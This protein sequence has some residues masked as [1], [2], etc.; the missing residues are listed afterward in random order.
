M[1]N[2]DVLYHVPRGYRMSRPENCPEKLYECMLRCWEVSPD[3][4]P[5]FEVRLTLST[6]R[7]VL[8]R[9]CLQFLFVF[10]DDFTTLT[11]PQYH[12]QS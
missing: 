2:R 3:N 10:F 9:F 4:R 5:T 8:A 7:I 6:S 11:G 1:S 12:N